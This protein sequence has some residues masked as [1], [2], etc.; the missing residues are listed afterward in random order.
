MAH[1]GCVVTPLFTVST[2]KLHQHSHKGLVSK[3]GSLA[4][5]ENSFQKN[6]LSFLLV[7]FPFLLFYLFIL[8]YLLYLMGVQRHSDKEHMSNLATRRFVRQ[9]NSFF[10]F[11]E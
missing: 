8:I 9:G 2:K 4:A 7:T 6:F 10:I 11:T 5:V 1:G 3:L